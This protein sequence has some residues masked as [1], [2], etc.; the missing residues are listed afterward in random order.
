MSNSTSQTLRIFVDEAGSLNIKPA[1]E[2]ASRKAIIMCAVAVPPSQEETLLS[3][4]PRDHNGNLL[5][6]SD[7]LM[8]E[9]HALR[10]V[11]ELLDS[12]SDVSLVLVDA[13]LDENYQVI[14]EVTEIANRVRTESRERRIRAPNLNYELL[15]KDA[16]IGVLGPAWERAG[17]KVT[18]LDVILDSANLSMGDRKRFK[19]ILTENSAK[20]GL[21]MEVSWCCNED[22][23]LLNVPDII[24]GIMHRRLIHNQLE[25]TADLLLRAWRDSRIIIQDGRTFVPLPT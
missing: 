5:K 15:V 17:C 8:S 3:L 20:H 2:S 19:Q 16:I 11:Q 21:H 23:P 22:Q 12:Q 1:S 18:C 4:L 7:K 9:R 14:S 6:S 13:G 25:E 10:F 24:A